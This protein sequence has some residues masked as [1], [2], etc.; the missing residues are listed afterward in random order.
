MISELGPYLILLGA[1]W[2]ASIGVPIPEDI[3][4]LTGGVACYYGKAHLAIMIPL[5]LFAVLSGDVFIFYLGRRWASNLLEHRMVR[6]LA[7]PEQVETLRSHFRNHELKTVFVARFLPGLRAVVFLIAGATKMRMGRFLTANGS[8]AMISVPTLVVVGYV[9]GHSFDRVKQEVREIEHV[10]V[11]VLG[12][13]VAV[14]LLWHFYSRAARAR[15]ASRLV[16][17]AEG[18]PTVPNAG[19][20][21][22]EPGGKASEP[23]DGAADSTMERA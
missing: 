22:S 18:K 2:V 14:W 8:A 7:K 17:V 16:Q 19:R 12:G 5:A 20:A 21:A 23:S 4:L 10:I 13:A 3:A 1:I 9:F 6:W 11:F 15:E